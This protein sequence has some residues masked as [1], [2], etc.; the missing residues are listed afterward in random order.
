[1]KVKMF[2]ENYCDTAQ[3][4]IN[5]WLEKENPVCYPHILVLI[6]C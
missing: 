3:D 5:E 6:H 2:I 4:K 1:M